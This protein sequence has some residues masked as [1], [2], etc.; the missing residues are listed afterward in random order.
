M[1]HGHL[2]KAKRQ[3]GLS[4]LSFVCFFFFF[5]LWRL[6]V[7]LAICSKIKSWVVG[8]IFRD[9]GHREVDVG[10]EIVSYNFRC[11]KSPSQN[12]QPPTPFPKV[13]RGPSPSPHLAIHPSIHA[14][15]FSPTH[16][17]LHSGCS[18]CLGGSLLY[19]FMH[20]CLYYHLIIFSLLP[21][22][23]VNSWQTQLAFYLLLN[24]KHSPVDS[25]GILNIP[26]KWKL[27]RLAYVTASG[28]EKGVLEWE[29]QGWDFLNANVMLHSNFN[30]V[31]L[32]RQ[33]FWRV[34]LISICYIGAICKNITPNRWI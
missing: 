14:A 16:S 20:R 7:H 28:T 18:S 15:R 30:E 26:A 17:S 1:R 2:V 32:W 23:V 25:V 19:C 21:S 6:W 34:I 33:L 29:H 13:F 24:A 3:N 12:L 4:F 11:F 22:A 27:Y 31:C 8:L 10:G 5:S 9:L